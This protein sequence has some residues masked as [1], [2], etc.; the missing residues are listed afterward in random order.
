MITQTKQRASFSFFSVAALIAAVFSFTTGA[1]WGL[2]LAGIAIVSGVIG[3]LLALL[4]GTRGGF[5]SA[6]AVLAG[7]AGIG[8]AVIK[9]L[10]AMAS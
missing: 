8:A 2:V 3:V 4:P 6:L 1:F 9:L 7:F 10:G 5:I